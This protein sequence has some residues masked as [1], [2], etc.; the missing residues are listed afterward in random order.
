MFILFQNQIE[1]LFPIC[2]T[3]DKR[4]KKV[5]LPKLAYRFDIDTA[6]LGMFLAKDILI[7]MARIP[8]V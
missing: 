5:S 8:N 2:H 1:S 3:D 7:I 4:A 6:C